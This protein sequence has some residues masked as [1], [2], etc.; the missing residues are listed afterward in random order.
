MDNLCQPGIIL[1]GSRNGRNCTRAVTPSSRLSSTLS[2]QLKLH[3]KCLSSLTLTLPG[4]KFSLSQER[5]DGVSL[6]PWPSCGA[7]Q[8][9]RIWDIDSLPLLPH[10]PSLSPLCYLQVSD[11]LSPQHSLTLEHIPAAS[12]WFGFLKYVFTATAFDPFGSSPKQTGP[13]LL[14]SFLGSSAVPGDPFLQATRSPSPT[15]HSD[16]FHM[17]KKGEPLLG[18]LKKCKMLLWNRNGTI[19]YK[20]MIPIK[21]L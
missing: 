16:P 4:S 6:L 3:L 5:R 12:S 10:S 17:G 8:V 18:C 2:W 1:R 14:G 13:D 7:L 9:P 15:V 11:F 19:K 21:R 20:V